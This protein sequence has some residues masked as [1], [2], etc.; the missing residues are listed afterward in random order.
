VARRRRRGSRANKP[1]HPSVVRAGAFE[2]LDDDGRV[3]ARL[4]PTAG[5]SVG[6]RATSL[7]LLGAGD[8]SELTLSV[9]SGGP[10]I[11]LSSG[12]TV[13]VAVGIVRSDEDRSKPTVVIAAHDGRGREVVS[14]VVGEGGEADVRLS[15]PGGEVC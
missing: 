1:R 5:A 7:V 15:G 4:G 9:D 11:R 14:V 8:E 6:E 2:L 10:S 13:R 12:G 3:V